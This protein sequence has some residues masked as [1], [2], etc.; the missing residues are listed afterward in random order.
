MTRHS[1]RVGLGVLVGAVL[2]VASYVGFRATHVEV[3]EQDGREYVIFPASARLLYYAYRPIMYL[4]SPLTGMRF[5][6]GPHQEAEA[7]PK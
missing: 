4:D 1:R 3:R 7:E 6:I 5:H 2:Y